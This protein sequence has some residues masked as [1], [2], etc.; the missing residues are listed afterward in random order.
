[1]RAQPRRVLAPVTVDSLMA[2]A[3]YTYAAAVASLAASHLLMAGVAGLVVGSALRHM[4]L[5]C[6]RG[7]ASC[8]GVCRP[9]RR[10]FVRMA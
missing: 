1:M 3:L 7:T 5:Q 4:A 10:A 6:P 2:L 9:D 8:A